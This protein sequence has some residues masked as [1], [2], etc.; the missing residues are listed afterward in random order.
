MPT[1]HEAFTEREEAGQFSL[2]RPPREFKRPVAAVDMPPVFPSHQ[3]QKAAATFRHGGP[4][5]VEDRGF[6]PLTSP[7]EIAP[8][9]AD[10]PAAPKTLAQTLARESEKDAD[11][12]RLLELWERLPEGGRRLLRQTAETLCGELPRAGRKK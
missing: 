12:A 4:F 5:E 8:P 7:A 3:N 10:A 2:N 9:Q 11:L 1:L 6:E